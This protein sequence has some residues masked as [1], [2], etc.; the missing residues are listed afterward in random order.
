[1]APANNV[2]QETIQSSG[3]DFL[4]FIS[5][6]GGRVQAWID[7]IGCLNGNGVIYVNADESGS[8]LGARINAAYAALPAYGGRIGVVSNGISN[9][10]DF[11]TPILLNQTAKVA[12]LFTAAGSSGKL[13]L[14]YVPLTGVAITVD[15]TGPFGMGESPVNVMEDITLANNDPNFG[16]GGQGSSAVG[17]LFG[18]SAG[19]N[20][21]KLSR[22]K[23]SGF[24]TGISLA[25]SNTWGMQFDQCSFVGN[26][27]GVSIAANLERML[28]TGCVF[29]ANGVG[30][31]NSGG[32]DATFHACSFDQ[33]TVAG[34]TGNLGLM[35][36]SNCHFENDSDGTKPS[37]TTHF[38]NSTGA[39]IVISGGEAF[40]N[41]SIGNTDY[42]FQI[43]GFAISV[44]D[45]LVGSAGRTASTVLNAL[46]PVKG[47]VRFV[48]TSPSFLTTMVAGSGAGSIVNSSY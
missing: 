44:S 36:F 10:Y 43:N 33:Q 6:H 20:L 7:A 27:T 26:T 1:M 45:L 4:H 42:Y 40:D 35:Q 16:P 12:T 39:A 9:R 19:A 15:Y 46:S 31:T 34:V 32:G 28:F 8:D 30:A 2:A 37:S 5:A 3:Q 23:I 29:G 25:T 38:I 47:A 14:N 24:G 17:I 11:S 22:C 21:G 13:I 41:L 48:N 18:S